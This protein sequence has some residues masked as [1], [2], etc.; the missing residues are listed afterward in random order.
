[1]S[2]M[3][4]WMC[5]ALVMGNVIGTGVFLLPASLAPYGLNSLFG[6][7]FTCAGALLLATVFAELARAYPC[8]G[9]PYVYPR[10]AFGEAT[11]FLTAWGY[12]VSLW[13]GNAAIAIGTV[14]SLAELVPALKSIVG[15]PA[16]AACALIWILTLLN[17][18]G[19]RYAG[20][21][22]IVTTVVKLIPLFA[23]IVLAVWL[24]ARRDATIIRLEPQPLT[25]SGIT[26]SATLT[27]WAL[28]GL[29]SATVPCESVVD[30]QR[31]IPR[32]TLM[33]TLLA[34]LIYIATSAVVL[35]LIPGSQLATSNAPFAD[36]LR[37]FWGD[38]AAATLALFTF[39]S[40][41]G[42]LNGW[43]L[44]QGE[45][46]RAMAREH[47]LPAILARESRFGTPGVALFV[48]SALITPLVLFN[49]T[50]SMV[51]IFTFL[52][53]VATS[54]FLVM[55]LL[56]S[57]AAIELA[58]KGR[59]S[60]EGTRLAGVLCVAIL[61]ALYSV[62]TLYG[63]GAEAFLWSIALLAVGIPIHYTMRWRRRVRAQHKPVEVIDG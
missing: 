25:L 61:A 24:L 35:L 34:A 49:Y 9:G 63:A 22:Q 42:T 6:W 27:L 30:P 5:L 44:V 37:L 12:L 11:G 17:W 58:R 13:V 55:Y 51:Q 56:C 18:R 3:G 29:E 15:A 48:T 28:L 53:L 45:M 32:A 23:V 59:L 2:K 33:G 52:V 1:M 39:V 16:V 26:A 57:L 60:L 14:A 41:L 31:T 36:V 46:P 7:I 54:A 19:I 20:G 8:A 38:R 21:F 10:M 40:G 50:A 43:I 47:A 62:W 4:F